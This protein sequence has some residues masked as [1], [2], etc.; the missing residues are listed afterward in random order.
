MLVSDTKSD[1]TVENFLNPVCW[2]DNV[3][4]RK[5]N[6]RLLVL[7]NLTGVVRSM[8]GSQKTQWAQFVSVFHF[9]V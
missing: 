5:S 8:S 3:H 4:N 2:N 1:F 6:Q 7:G 9:K